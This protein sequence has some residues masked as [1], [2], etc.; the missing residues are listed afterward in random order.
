MKFKSIQESEKTFKQ[1]STE[2][3]QNNINQLTKD[4]LKLMNQTRYQEACTD[5][6]KTKLLRNEKLL[7]AHAAK[8]NQIVDE[9]NEIQEEYK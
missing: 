8:Y 2:K 1:A 6:M 5:L 9:Y 4:I 7:I 3:F